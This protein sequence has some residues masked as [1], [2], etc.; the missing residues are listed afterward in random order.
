MG[1][2]TADSRVPG[3]GEPIG[4]RE[5]R[6]MNSRGRELLLR[7]WDFPLFA[8]L[9]RLH[10][11]SLENAAIL[12]A[13]CG[14]GYGLTL[15]WKQFRP[16]RLV[17]FDI[18]PSQVELARKRNVPAT[19]FTGDIA[20]L[21]LAS[22]SFDAVFVCGVLHHCRTWRTGLAEV[23][24]VLKDGGVLLL[25]EPDTLLMR[26]E[27]AL[28]GHSPALE[29]GFSHEALRS[30]MRTAGLMAV[31]QRALYFGLFSCFLCVKAAMD[32]SAEYVV[33]R[34]LLRAPS[35][36]EFAAGQQAPA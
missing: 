32:A 22:G 5:R 13:G 24:R 26:M 18:L 34:R 25:A 11:I 2:D 35:E 29:A 27:R 6:V 7:H 10:G 20:A 23:A 12:D 16:S 19:V 33:A 36:S 1:N 4:E 31:E 30:E 14:S 9:L 17:G 21:Q 8:S 15:I 28:S 3:G